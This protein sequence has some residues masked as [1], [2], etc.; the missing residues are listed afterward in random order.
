[1]SSKT[2][3]EESSLSAVTRLDIVTCFYTAKCIM[4]YVFLNLYSATFSS[5][6]F[7]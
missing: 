3:C 4:R 5:S 2:L 7:T 1:M 6:V